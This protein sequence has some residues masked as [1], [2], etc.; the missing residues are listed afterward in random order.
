MSCDYS[1]YELY[2]LSAICG[3]GEARSEHTIS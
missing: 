2:V 1:A 3:G